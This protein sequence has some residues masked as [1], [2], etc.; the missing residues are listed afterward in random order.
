MENI[1][2]VM[3]Y[4]LE[5]GVESWCLL[6][7]KI[8]SKELLYIFQ[9]IKKCDCTEEHNL[10]KSGWISVS[11]KRIALSKSFDVEV[12]WFFTYHGYI[13]ESQNNFWTWNRLLDNCKHWNETCFKSS[14]FS[15]KFEE[16]VTHTRIWA[17]NHP[18]N[19]FRC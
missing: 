9:F 7:K 19:I 18:I 1:T 17:Q 16:T 14:K 13:I 3:L 5:N 11:Y 15:W 6:I 4:H 12:D 10:S 2:I 8:S